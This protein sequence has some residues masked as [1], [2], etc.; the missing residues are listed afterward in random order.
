MF[1][2]DERG[3]LII[4]NVFA[5][6]RFPTATFFQI[7]AEFYRILHTARFSSSGADTAARLTL[8][9]R[10]QPPASAEYSTP[11]VAVI[12]YKVAFRHPPED[13]L[14][15]G[16]AI[17]GDEFSAILERYN[18]DSVEDITNPYTT[19]V[20]SIWGKQYEQKITL[21]QL[22]IDDNIAEEA[23]LAE[24]GI[25]AFAD[26]PGRLSIRVKEDL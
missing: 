17:T 2:Y 25:Y 18:L 21:R 6:R 13:R 4:D 23:R 7:G 3:Y 1:E 20:N 10:Y 8:M 14:K 11:E 24:R 12:L 15:V 16:R 26:A 9:P 22:R 5:D 19:T